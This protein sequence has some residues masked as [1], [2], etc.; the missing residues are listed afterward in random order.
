MPV[1]R[2][3]A[4][5]RATAHPAGR[6]GG[7]TPGRARTPLA[8]RSSLGA[9]AFAS[10]LGTALTSAAIGDPP[11]TGGRP[12]LP[13]IV[14]VSRQPLPGPE[15]GADWA[16]IPGVGPRDRIAAAGG[17]LLVREP[18]GRLRVLV[19]ERTLFDV[20]DPCVSWD[21]TRVL[22]SGLVHPDSSWRIFEIGADGAG[23]HQVTRSDR[24]IPL[25]QFGPAAARFTRYDDFDPCWLPDGRVLLAS[26]R[27]PMLAELSEFLATNLFVIDAPGDRPRRVTTERSGAEEPAVDPATGRV[28]YARWLV[29]LDRP[30]NVT[31]DG[32]TMVDAQALTKDI[33]NVWETISVTPDGRA[34]RLHG[35]DPR[36][37][38]GLVA[39]KPALFPDGR[40]LSV[41]A[42]N[43]ALAPS[44]GLS[45]V[46]LF[47]PGASPGRALVG[48]RPGQ[49]PP[50]PA[51]FPPPAPEIPCATD[52][53]PLPDGRVLLSFSRRAGTDFG[54]ALCDADGSGL[55]PLLDLPGT[56]EIDAQVLAPSQVPRILPDNV[57]PFTAELPPT[58]AP[59]TY[60][61]PGTFRFDCMN[62]FANAPVDAPIPDAPPI[63]RGT[64]IRFFMNF[65]RT[66]AAGR[67]PSIL[68]RDAPLSERGAVL[69]NGL[70]ADVP[71]FGQIVDAA[72][73]VLV[74]GTGGPVHLAGFSYGRHGGWAQC[75]GCHAGHSVIEIPHTFTD[76]EWT[77][78][79]TS[80]RVAAS[81]EWVPKGREAPPFPA[82]RAV[83]RRAKEGGLDAAWVAA[84]DRR[85]SVTLRWDLPI[86]VTRFVLHGIGENAA[87]GTTLRVGE[88]RIALLRGGEVVG[89]VESTGPALPGGTEARVAPTVV[90]GAR[91][92]I[93][94]S[95]GRVRGEAVT[96]LAEVEVIARLALA[97]PNP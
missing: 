26:T 4:S 5:I 68:F 49:A 74:G 37:R 70:P 10:I 48:F 32:L 38:E 65:Q 82:R 85:E 45:G 30:S 46:R 9:A 12:A 78:L 2:R 13:P 64:R 90:D 16:A 66:N 75:V 34:A 69:E 54:L 50:S 17:R 42:A 87:E 92:E 25:D 31:R 52:P 96:G 59:A 72:G 57:D 83:D 8:R 63:A 91:I 94:S 11:P 19:D 22:F 73:K 95:S 89:G 67:D 77:N 88:C 23:L 3:V 76:C 7:R 71:L 39:Y 47:A 44:P 40:V 84:G 55:E 27:Y 18:D 56:H 86:E 80:A 20:A 28:V 61:V 58:E 24:E 97:E 62:L 15:G 51:E 14:F 93:V 81:S 60:L 29:N 79:A 36:S 21:A 43:G 1:R 53:A 41:F 6:R 33:G 35:G